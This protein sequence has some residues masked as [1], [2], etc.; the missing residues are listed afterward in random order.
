MNSPHK[1]LNKV[2]RFTGMPV[3]PIF[4]VLLPKAFGDAQT[5][6]KKCAIGL[7]K[8]SK[9][10][11]NCMLSQHNHNFKPPLTFFSAGYTYTRLTIQLHRD[12]KKT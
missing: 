9:H 2:S 6:S 3:T 10:S 5:F 12:K 4:S 11:Q 1:L 8:E 7:K